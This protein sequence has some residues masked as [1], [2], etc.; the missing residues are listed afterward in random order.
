METTAT[1]TQ[2]S[3]PGTDDS[4]TKVIPINAT[5]LEHNQRGNPQHSEQHPEQLQTTLNLE[6]ENAGWGDLLH[7]HNPQN[8]FCIISKNVS[9]LNP[10]SLN[11]V[12]IAT[13]LQSKQASVFL[14][15]ETNTAW[16][17]NNTEC[18]PK[19][20]PTSLSYSQAGSI[21]QCREEQWVVPTRWHLHYCPR[22]VG[23]LCHWMGPGQTPWQMALPRDGGPTWQMHNYCICISCLCTGI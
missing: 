2:Q 1:Q 7:F 12:V 15:Q 5:P 19:P 3:H 18:N 23:K 9:M 14:A 13:E 21:F 17:P 6:P 22:T 10:Q 4:L 16:T 8:Y 11:M 20:M